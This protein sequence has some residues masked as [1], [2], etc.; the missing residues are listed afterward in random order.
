MTRPFRILAALILVTS[1]GLAWPLEVA[2]QRRGPATRGGG[3]SR[4]VAVPR[5]YSTPYHGSGTYRPYY[6]SRYYYPYSYSRYYS[7]YYAG[8][9]FGIGFGLGWSG[10]WGSYGYGYGYPYYSY[11]YPPYGYPPYGYPSY[12]YPYGAPYGYPSPDNSSY[13]GYGPTGSATMQPQPPAVSS[14]GHA[15]D[16]QAPQYS[17]QYAAGE[18]GS[19]GTLSLR[20]NPADAVIVIDDAVWDRSDGDS[21]FSIDLVE[22]PHRVEVRKAGYG[23]YVRTIDVRSGAG[24]TVNVSLSP[25]GPGQAQVSVRTGTVAA[26]AVQ[27]PRDR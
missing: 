4:G 16:R 27:Q 14:S 17:A 22:G 23:S 19:F 6:N 3:S 25:A 15:T 13:G 10:Y 8:F 24:A 21:Q 11:G 1:V 9:G 20:V 26:R 5:T 12:G 18:R 7:P 2:A